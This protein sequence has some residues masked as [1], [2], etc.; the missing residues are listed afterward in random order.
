MIVIGG[1][2]QSCKTNTENIVNLAL[3]ET[4]ACDFSTDNVGQ[5]RLYQIKRR[6]KNLLIPQKCTTCFGLYSNHHALRT[7]MLRHIRV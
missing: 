3:V 7:E 1:E 4:L 6:K 2:A 5:W